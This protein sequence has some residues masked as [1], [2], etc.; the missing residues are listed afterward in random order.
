MLLNEEFIT[1]YEE[2]SELNEAKADTQKLIDFAGK[3]LAD[4]FLAIKDRLK[5]PE[6]DLYYWIKNKTP[7]DLEQ[8]IL[9]IENTKS[10]NKAKK[11]IADQGAKLVCESEHWLVYH[12]TSFEAAQVYGR[13]T[14]W[15]ITGIDGAGDHY[16]NGYKK[17]GATFYFFIS[18]VNYDPRGRD[19]KFSLAIYPHE[20]YWFNDEI[21]FEYEVYNQVDWQLS[22]LS[23]IPYI[24]EVQIPGI[25][26]NRLVN[27]EEN[28]GGICDDCQSEVDE[29]ELLGTAYGNFVCERC[30]DRYINS[31]DGLVEYFINI[32]NRD[33][34]PTDFSKEK[35]D[36]IISVWVD[37]KKN[38][39]LLMG[40]S[41]S[42]IEE[43]ETDFIK[44]LIAANIDIDKNI[45]N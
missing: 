29:D 16:W 5:T 9:K 4:R 31:E 21:D 20:V 12:I 37:A 3:N 27:R 28:S 24:E 30:W 45:F 6:N 38:R 41:D 1:I 17:E 8:T 44:E 11:E 25:D 14:K 33:S 2:L 22:D 19:S 34:K 10:G 40:L 23:A 43:Y 32:A 39:Q 36:K 42:A 26:F 13:D 7:D 35:L 18:K 15:C